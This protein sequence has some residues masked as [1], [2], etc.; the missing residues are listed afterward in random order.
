MIERGLAL[1]S[2]YTPM[3]P[4]RTVM[5]RQTEVPDLRGTLYHAEGTPDELLQKVHAIATNSS[6]AFSKPEILDMKEGGA[7][8]A[9]GELVCKIAYKATRDEILGLSAVRA[10]VALYEGFKRI[11]HPTQ[12]EPTGLGP[13]YYVAPQLHAA[14]VPDAGSRARQVVVMSREIGRIPTKDEI[15]ATKDRESHYA[16]AIGACGLSRELV[17]FDDFRQNL[18]VSHDPE[19]DSL[20]IVKFDILAATNY[21]EGQLF[22]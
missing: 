3:T 8:V 1:S 21:A 12:G 13:H 2:S 6:R 18:L 7:V 4:D 11:P 9:D 20:R 5:W 19:T 15:P 22:S 17:S 16:A 10:N 14:F